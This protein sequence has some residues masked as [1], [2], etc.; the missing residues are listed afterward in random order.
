MMKDKM[1]EIPVDQIK[2]TQWDVRRA[3]ENKEELESLSRSIDSDG[4]LNP[5]TVM[6]NGDHTYTVVAGRRRLKACKMLGMKTVPVFIKGEMKQ[7]SEIR[8]VTLIE[9]LHRRELTAVEKSYGVLAVYEAAGYTPQ[10]AIQG[11]KWIH[12]NRITSQ[13]STFDHTLN[14]SLIKDH[15]TFKADSTFKPD[16]K[17]IDLC[18]AIG[19]P[20]NTQYQSLETVIHVPREV[21]EAAEKHDLGLGYQVLLTRPELREHPELQKMIIDKVSEIKKKKQAQ[22]YVQQITEKVKTGQIEKVGS[23]YVEHVGKKKVPIRELQLPSEL[24]LP[25]NSECK[26]M[27]YQFTGRAITR[28][29]YNYTEEM[30]K[31]SKPHQLSVVKSVLDKELMTLDDNVYFVYLAAKQML[32]LINN[33]FEA[34]DLKKDLIS[35]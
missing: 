13:R 2:Q 25:L 26:T 18:E 35:K 14:I 17:F 28:D 21:L 32:E 6:K 5:L 30:I 19:I 1:L 22:D 10:Q 29:E 7:E 31:D 34:R 4:L 9:N 12:N 27:L 20:A 24:F 23:T 3:E 16:Q 15:K 8:K 11:T 33:E